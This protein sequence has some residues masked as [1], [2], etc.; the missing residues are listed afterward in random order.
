VDEDE[1]DRPPVPQV[2]GIPPV[3]RRGPYADTRQVASDG[4]TRALGDPGVIEGHGGVSGDARAAT[5]G[6]ASLFVL[7]SAGRLAGLAFVVAVTSRVAPD[8]FGRYS[9]VAAVVLVANFLADF[10]TSSAIT[11][12]VSRSPAEADDLLAGTLPGSFVLGLVAYGAAV[13]FAYAA[14]S[15]STVVDMAIGAAAVPAASVLSSLLGALDG[16]SLIARRARITAVQTFVTAAGAVPVLLGTSIRWALVALAVAPALSAVLAAV[17]V[18]RAGI[19]R[20]PLRFDARRMAGLLRSAIPFAV[21]GGLAALTMRFDVILLSLFRSAAE[22]AR[23]DLALR[24]LE[25]AGYLS[26]ALTA[27]LL[28]ILSRRLGARDTDGAGRA[29]KE[30]L[31]VLYLVGIPISVGLAILARPIITVTAGPGYSGA[32]TPFAVMAAGQWLTWV[33]YV[34]GSLLMAGD[35]VRRGLAVVG[36]VTAVTITLDLAIV[37]AAGAVGAAIA[38]LL[39]W[40]F[41]AVA[42][43]RFHRRTVGIPTTLPPARIV[44]PALAMGLAVIPVRNALLP[45]PVVVG[46][47]VFAAGVALTGAV[48]AADVR[49]LSRVLG[50]TGPSTPGV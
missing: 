37:P 1:H 9:T 48:T 12:R 43:D 7:Q 2:D 44:L 14:Y 16:A 40:T 17:A 42:L 20:S 30:A 33:I 21:T 28:F 25:A 13:A 32:A 27:P 35:F 38:M 5:R 6:A 50:R 15:G 39:A 49:R 24:L 26:T 34:Q 31:R 10:G 47:A 41:A 46:A 3:K 18:R 8:Q 45:V 36:L 23:Y 29:Y 4:R 22:T 11:R 19:W